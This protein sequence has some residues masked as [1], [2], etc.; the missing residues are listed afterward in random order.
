MHCV[1]AVA[2]AEES[3]NKTATKSSINYSGKE[4][5]EDA[6]VRKQKK[7]SPAEESDQLGADDRTCSET[8]AVRDSS[9]SRRRQPRDHSRD[10]SE[11]VQSHARKSSRTR[12]SSRIRPESA[13]GSEHKHSTRGTETEDAATHSGVKP[14]TKDHVSRSNFLKLKLH[15]EIELEI[16]FVI[17]ITCN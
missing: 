6:V 13:L 4:G 5:E 12:D 8:S 14:R 7:R 2:V 1:F 11:I 3:P 10:A 16:R 9:V 15:S 17:I